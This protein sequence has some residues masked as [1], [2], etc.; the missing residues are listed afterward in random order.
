M[1]GSSC[2]GIWP[3]ISEVT[4]VTA[5]CLSNDK[6][7]LA[8]GDDLGYVK[9]FK[10]PVKV[11]KCFLFKHE[12]LLSLL[13]AFFCKSVEQKNNQKVIW[14]LP[15]RSLRS[16]AVLDYGCHNLKGLAINVIFKNSCLKVN[17]VRDCVI[18]IIH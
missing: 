1:L 3:V 13:L 18:E 4:E 9:L 6:K 14:I 16:S 11:K 12:L 8:T 5:A 7:L 10:Y 17:S 2:E 15:L